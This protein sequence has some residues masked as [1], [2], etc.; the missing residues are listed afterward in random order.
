MSCRQDDAQGTRPRRST[1][2]NVP[3]HTRASNP[4]PREPCLAYATHLRA[5]CR[6]VRARLSSSGFLLGSVQSGLMVLHRRTKLQ[7]DGPPHSLPFAEQSGEPLLNFFRPRGALCVPLRLRDGSRIVV[8]NTH[9]NAESSKS[10]RRW[11]VAAGPWGV[12]PRPMRPAPAPDTGRMQPLAAGGLSPQSTPC[13]SAF[14]TPGQRTWRRSACPRCRWPR[15]P[16]RRPRQRPCPTPVVPRPRH[17]PRTSGPQ[18]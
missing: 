16:D 18:L 7:P 4:G 12:D 15:L 6:A 14:C 2:D 17:A 3:P 8:A 5:D 1:D 11:N 13:L 9:T 10:A